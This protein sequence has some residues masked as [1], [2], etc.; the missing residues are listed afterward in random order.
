MWWIQKWGKWVLRYLKWP[1]SFSVY[2]FPRSCDIFHV[3]SNLE[4]THGLSSDILSINVFPSYYQHASVSFLW[5]WQYQ[6]HKVWLWEKHMIQS[7]PT[8]REGRV[9]KSV[10]YSVHRGIGQNP[11]RQ[12]P[13]GDR[14]PSRD[15]PPLEADSPGYWRLVAATAAVVTHPTGM[16]SCCKWFCDCTFCRTSFV[17]FWCNPF[18]QIV[19]CLSSFT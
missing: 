16:H 6:I 8:A 1:Y 15:R 7:L 2:I 14:P 4:K 12:T 18:L 17:A 10:C 5:T 11:R 3:W 9:F 13:S 19:T